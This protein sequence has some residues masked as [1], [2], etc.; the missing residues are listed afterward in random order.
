MIWQYFQRRLQWYFLFHLVFSNGSLPLPH[1]KLESTCSSH[2]SGL[3]LWFVLTKR[4]RQKWGCVTF[5]IQVP[6]DHQ[7]REEAQAS[8]MDKGKAI[9]NSTKAPGIL[10]DAF[11]DQPSYWLIGA[12]R[13]I[14]AE[15]LWVKRT[16][17]S[18]KIFWIEV[19]NRV[20]AKVC[21]IVGSLSLQIH[22]I[23]SP[24]SPSL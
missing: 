8:L 21:L 9:W 7:C 12:K 17:L 6:W 16:N 1:Q 22:L 24:H 23:V 11:L 10:S 2:G 14:P 4:M 15:V 18:V 3:V 13:M 5:K 20:L 19:K